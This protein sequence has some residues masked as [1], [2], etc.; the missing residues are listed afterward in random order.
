MIDEEDFNEDIEAG[1]GTDDANEQ[2]NPEVND[3]AVET[4]EAAMNLAE[5]EGFHVVQDGTYV[6]TYPTEEDAQMFIDGH[7]KPQGLEARIIEGSAAVAP[8]E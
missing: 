3:E 8:I 6:G 5:T 1:E 7:I 4:S 2:P